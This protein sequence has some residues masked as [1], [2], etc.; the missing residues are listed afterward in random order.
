MERDLK[1]VN[2]GK[3]DAVRRYLDVVM[4]IF[5]SGETTREGK[6]VRQMAAAL[7]S[8]LKGLDAFP[9]IDLKE[10][11][12]KPDELDANL[13]ALLSEPVEFPEI[14]LPDIKFPEEKNCPFCGKPKK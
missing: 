6:A 13:D 1:Q 2:T 12:I 9:Q 3:L 10:L 11:G 5:P 7:Q 4:M 14:N 8:S